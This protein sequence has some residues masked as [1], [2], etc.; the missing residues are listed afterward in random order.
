MA[1]ILD[2]NIDYKLTV[3]KCSFKEK[4]KWTINIWLGR[5]IDIKIKMRVKEDD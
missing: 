4:L 2:H 1:G 3:S 5:E